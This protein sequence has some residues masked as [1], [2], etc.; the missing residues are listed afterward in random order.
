MGVE[1]DLRAT[2]AAWRERGADRISPVR[3]H[4]IEA[5]QR[6]A[7]G[8]EGEARRMLE[9]RLAALV[10]DYAAILAQA[11]RDPDR[12]EPARDRRAMLGEAL[13]LLAGRAGQDGAPHHA[14]RPRM[15]ALTRAQQTWAE[16]RT[17][18]QVRH[19]LG[20]T[21]EG[22][23]PLNSAR[24]VH[25]ALG[26]MGACSPAYLERFLAYLDALA[27]LEQV[28]RHGARS[29]NASAPSPR[30]ATS[31][32]RPRKSRSRRDPADSAN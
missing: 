1:L 4:Y 23:G 13:D 8:F 30:P 14:S 28:D 5:L 12:P 18:S 29:A 6:R 20:Q 17:R 3:F 10:R 25:R 16:V 11:G 22:A 7:A 26:V 15:A 32:R 24:L 19:S 21:A 31:A 9:D 27:W 2:L